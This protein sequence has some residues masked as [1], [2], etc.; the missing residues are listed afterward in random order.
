[1]SDTKINTPNSNIHENNNENYIKQLNKEVDETK[2]LLIKNCDRIIERGDNIDDLDSKTDALNSSSLNF[3][4]NTVRLRN[5]LW[6]KDKGCILVTIIIIVVII[7]IIA[8]TNKK[9]N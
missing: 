1:M 7:L 6:W 8:L 2:H 3:R 5:N 9:K 4:Y